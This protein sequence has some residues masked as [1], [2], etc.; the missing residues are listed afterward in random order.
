[1]YAYATEPDYADLADQDSAKVDSILEAEARDQLA[2]A[3]IDALDFAMERPND[4]VSAMLC[5][6]KGDDNAAAVILRRMF[7]DFQH[8]HVYDEC[9]RERVIEELGL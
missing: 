6:V 3:H 2:T 4:V 9:E 5:A 8:V 7:E 1:M